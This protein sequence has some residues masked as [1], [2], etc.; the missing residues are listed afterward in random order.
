M[1]ELEVVPKT[2]DQPAKKQKK[3]RMKLRTSGLAR[4]VLGPVGRW[5]I[6]VFGLFVIAGLVIPRA[7]DGE[8]D[9]AEPV[10]SRCGS[11]RRCMDACPAG[12][13][14]SPGVVDVARCLQGFAARPDAL[15]AE[16]MARW[17]AR[18]YGCQDCQSV[19]PHNVGVTTGNHPVLGEIGPSVS[20]RWFLA[21]DGAGLGSLFH[22][23]A[24][25]MS[26][27]SKDAL[28]RNALVAAG[29]SGSAGLASSVAPFVGS[30]SPAISAAAAW[31]LG[32]ISGKGAPGV[33]KS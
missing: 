18:L 23:T 15:P 24:M 6:I 3:P 21:Q 5:L 2:A 11:C 12:A 7:L 1:R 33:G 25:G 26:W 13:I 32:R 29:N 9:R 8:P 10:P 27:I 14:V 17:G 16:V 20:L 28:V 19:C 22:G 31:A 4:F 30:S